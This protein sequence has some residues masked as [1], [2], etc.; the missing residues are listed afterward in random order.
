MTPFIALLRGVNVV[1]H[2]IVAMEELRTT[3]ADLGYRNVR[4]ALA[5]GNVVFEGKSARTALLEKKLEKDLKQALALETAVMVRHPR[6]WQA[7]IARNPFER[8][9]AADP[10]RFL[11]LVLKEEPS[12]GA[13]E[14]TLAGNQG[15][16]R[17]EVL[18]REAFIVYP[19]GVGKS[20][21]NLKPLGTGTARN[22][23]TVL[24]LRTMTV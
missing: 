20:R 7:I 4:P 14:A 17:L 11:V 15:P 24:R 9:A 19:N 21:L 16:E 22:W 10:S 12:R 23:N 3:L 8:E 2:R 13:V 6:E 18:G 1:G 5:S